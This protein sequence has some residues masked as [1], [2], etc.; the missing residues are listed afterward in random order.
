VVERAGWGKDSGMLALPRPFS[1]EGE[2]SGC[3]LER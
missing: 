3:V 1:K 2:D